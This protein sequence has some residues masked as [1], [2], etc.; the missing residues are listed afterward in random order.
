MGSYIN[1]RPHSLPE[2]RA[3]VSSLGP[4]AEETFE[5]FVQDQEKLAKSKVKA[6]KFSSRFPSQATR[7]GRYTHFDL[8]HH[9]KKAGLS[10]YSALNKPE[11]LDKYLAYLYDK[12]KNLTAREIDQVSMS[13]LFLELDLKELCAHRFLGAVS[14]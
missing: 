1:A 2:L 4:Y 5:E 10:K 6:L 14:Q 11:M 13:S 9:V 12:Y 3:E 7:I 8:Q